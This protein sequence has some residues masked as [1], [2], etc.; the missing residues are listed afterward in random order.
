MRTRRDR[1]ARLGAVVLMVALGSVALAGCSPAPGTGG[2]LTSHRTGDGAAEA[3][4][5]AGEAA[6]SSWRTLSWMALLLVIAAGW[7]MIDGQRITAG[8][9]LAAAV[10]VAVVPAVIAPLLEMIFWPLAI[11]VAA[12]IASAVAWV[13][14][15]AWQH[16]RDVNGS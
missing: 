15:R 13:A 12:L 11:G 3:C 4:D 1:L 5:A 9:L 7:A 6:G 10:V 14:G 16:W 8:L 2:W